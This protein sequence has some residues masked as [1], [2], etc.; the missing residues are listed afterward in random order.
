MYVRAEI[1]IQIML[2]QSSL[3]SLAYAYFIKQYV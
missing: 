2:F 1:L 3:S